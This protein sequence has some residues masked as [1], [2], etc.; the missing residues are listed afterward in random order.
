MEVST[1]LTGSTVIRSEFA[2]LLDVF[3]VGFKVQ[4]GE[5]LDKSRSTHATPAE[6]ADNPV[7]SVTH[8]TADEHGFAV[9]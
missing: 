5:V 6:T 9:G 3:L 7:Q 1:G 4:A 2:P 8:F